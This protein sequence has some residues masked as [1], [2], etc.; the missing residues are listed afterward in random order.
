MFYDGVNKLIICFFLEGLKHMVQQETIQI[1][2]SYTR[3]SGDMKE[4]Y[5]SQY[6]TDSQQC[7]CI[8]YLMF[9]RLLTV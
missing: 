7:K 9:K 8:I 2:M 1:D 3:V 6:L 5:I 4:I